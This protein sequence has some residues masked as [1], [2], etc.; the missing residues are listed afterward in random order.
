MMT[1]TPTFDEIDNALVEI[2]MPY[3]PSET[4]GLI[5]GMICGDVHANG[6][7]LWKKHPLS[8]TSAAKPLNELFM[9]TIQQFETTDFNLSPLLPTEELLGLQAEALLQWCEGLLTG[10]ELAGINF[11]H[12]P[13][14]IQEVLNDLIEISQADIQT[15]STQQFTEEDFTELFEYIRMGALFIFTELRLNDSIQDPPITLPNYH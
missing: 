2:D 11:K 13:Q 14:E 7:H 4:H 3:S 9:A 5:C 12:P 6:L 8:Q 15:L 1:Q 10:L